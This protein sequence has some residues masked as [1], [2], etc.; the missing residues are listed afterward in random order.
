MA[1]YF[2]TDGIRGVANVQITPDLA[3]RCGNALAQ[4]G[5]KKVLIGR[6]TRRSG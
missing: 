3:T 1:I 4:M 2:G 5:A 6:D